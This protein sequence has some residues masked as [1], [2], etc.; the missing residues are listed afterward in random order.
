M[1]V[2]ISSEQQGAA[3]ETTQQDSS[4]LDRVRQQLLAKRYLLAPVLAIAALSHFNG[5][6]YDPF[7]GKSL[8]PA[9]DRYDPEKDG[10]SDFS[11]KKDRYDLF[12][13][14]LADT[15]KGRNKFLNGAVV[16]DGFNIEV[17]EELIA[18]TLKPNEAVQV[19]LIDPS[20]SYD[21][22][23]LNNVIVYGNDNGYLFVDRKL[24]QQPHYIG[25]PVLGEVYPSEK[26]TEEGINY[27]PGGLRSLPGQELEIS[28]YRFKTKYNPTLGT[29]LAVDNSSYLLY[30]TTWPIY[31]QQNISCQNVGEKVISEV[32]LPRAYRQR[33]CAYL[34]RLS[35]VIPNQHSIF[36]DRI[37]KTYDS[38]DHIEPYD[39]EMTLSIPYTK[40]VAGHSEAY[41]IALHESMH[42]AYFNFKVDHPVIEDLRKAYQKMERSMN[43]RMPTYEEQYDGYDI[44]NNEPSWA[45]ITEST[46]EASVLGEEDSGAGHPWDEPTEMASSTS[47]VLAIYPHEFL[48]NYQQLS[49]SQR[50]AVKS[51]VK[52]T[53]KFVVTATGSQEKLVKLIPE[54]RLVIGKLGLTEGDI[55][56]VE[57]RFENGDPVW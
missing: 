35:R 44:A 3:S 1:L 29:R 28:K 9:Y 39:K 26:Q 24:Q 12:P 43:Y 37:A 7:Y 48:E 38:E 20:K 40:D 16:I 2:M 8:G 32:K 53:L 30:K 47:T 46:Y 19:A 56:P 55:Q 33:V 22:L 52:A 34:M 50:K 45:A 18:K 31:F 23:V 6:A 41:G 49:A 4:L 5:D 57:V 54:Y 11:L 25:E 13:V 51:V 36:L 10:G 27:L 14:R 21:R 42:A 17:D 15:L